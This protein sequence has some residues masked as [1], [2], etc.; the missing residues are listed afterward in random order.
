MKI[1][2]FRG[3]MDDNGENA[4]HAGPGCDE[5]LR[6]VRVHRSEFYFS[7]FGSVFMKQQIR[8]KLSY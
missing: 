7:T 6:S 3:K 1:D 4:L 2:S 8:W 5:M